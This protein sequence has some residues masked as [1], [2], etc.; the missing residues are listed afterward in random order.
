MTA[1]VLACLKQRNCLHL[2]TD[3][4]KYRQDQSVVAFS[5]KVWPVSH[6]PGVVTC[7]GNAAAVPLFG[8]ALADEFPSWDDMIDGAKQGLAR[9]AEVVSEW[10]LSHA[11]VLLAGI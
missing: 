5:T 10:G 4:A 8:S 1:I 11:A 3:A 9:P 6:W 7:T 2:A